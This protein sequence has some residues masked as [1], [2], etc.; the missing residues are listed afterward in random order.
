MKKIINKI[1]SCF[2]DNAKKLTF[3]LGR[4]KALILA[5]GFSFI[6][7]FSGIYI[8]SIRNI[9]IKNFR[10]N[11]SQTISKLHE[12]GIDIAY[13]NIDFNT[14]F[15]FPL[16]E[17]DNLQI[18]NIKGNNRVSLQLNKIKISSDLIFPSS[19]R[20][21]SV[22]G[23]KFSFDKEEYILSSDKTFLEITSE[24]KQFE[25]LMLHAENIVL[26]DFAN[27]K[28]IAFLVETTSHENT[29]S[30]VTLPHYESFFELK[31]MKI[32][33]LVNYPLTSEL[34]LLYMKSEIIGK[35]TPE[36]YLMTSLET[37]LKNGGYL[38]VPNLVVQ[39]A[40]LTLVARGNIHFNEKFSPRIK[41]N[42]TS[43]GILRLIDDL[44]KN[45]FLD[46][47]NVFVAN[48]LLSNKAEKI[49]PEDTEFTISTPI[50]YSDKKLSVENLLIK[51]FSK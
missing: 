40:P 1:F 48:I 30:N 49:K 51:D 25:E 28:K 45:E 8:T 22:K 42:T 3:F 14:L 5:C 4:S 21:N 31:D 18:Y 12:I 50:Q 24:N 19:L 37:W 16:A 41:F 39:W 2:S 32:N 23:G 43:K 9:A 46:S 34:K 7:I 29:N 36:Q 20:F 27:I 15:F 11:L 44:R 35:F 13:D 38:E 10:W 26:Q 33:G 47:K 6:L 17:I